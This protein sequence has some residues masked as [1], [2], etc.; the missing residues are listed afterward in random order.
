MQGGGS[1]A[2]FECLKVMALGS[3]AC[4]CWQWYS[5]S[6]SSSSIRSTALECIVTAAAAAVSALRALLPEHQLLGYAVPTGSTSLCFV[7]GIYVWKNRK[8]SQNSMKNA[9]CNRHTV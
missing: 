2:L 6:S 5:S 9:S 1:G 4:W 7:R 8:T 3:I